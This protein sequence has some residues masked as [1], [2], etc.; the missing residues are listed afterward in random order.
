MNDLYNLNVCTIIRMYN[1]TLSLVLSAST[2]YV[3]YR[4]T[5]KRPPTIRAPRLR[6]DTQTTC[7]RI[8]GGPEIPRGLSQKAEGRARVRANTQAPYIQT[9]CS[10]PMHENNH[11]S[12]PKPGDRK[13]Q[14]G[15]PP[16]E[17][18]KPQAPTNETRQ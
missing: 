14:P 4:E 10:L 8:Q 3:V 1:C 16:Q 9:D 18:I 7:N 5:A 17:P 13:T 6:A 15:G 11:S 2:A 12:W